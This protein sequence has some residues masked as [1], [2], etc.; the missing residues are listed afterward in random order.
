[1]FPNETLEH[2]RALLAEG[3][4]VRNAASL[5][6]VGRLRLTYALYP[7]KLEAEKARRRKNYPNRASKNAAYWKEWAKRRREAEIATLLAESEDIHGEDPIEHAAERRLALERLAPWLAD[8]IPNYTD[9]VVSDRLARLR[10][11]EI[12][13]RCPQA[14]IEIEL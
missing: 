13:R 10:H 8:S 4:S 2:A 1:M 11:L 6:N 7:E 9:D 14:F 3:Y 5:L 12:Y